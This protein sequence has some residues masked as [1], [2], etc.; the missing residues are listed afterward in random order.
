MS[1]FRPRLAVDDACAALL[2]G[3]LAAGI[4]ASTCVSASALARHPLLDVGGMIPMP[5][6]LR[7]GVDSAPGSDGPDPVAADPALRLELQ[8]RMERHR[9]QLLPG[10]ESRLRLEGKAAADVWLRHE[11]LERGQREAEALRRRAPAH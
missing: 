6:P 3:R 1:P 10:Y 8:R 11:A 5:P 9:R 7:S 2:S 4:A